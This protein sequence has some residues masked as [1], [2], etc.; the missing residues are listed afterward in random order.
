VPWTIIG[1]ILTAI[2]IVIAIASALT[3]QIDKKIESQINDPAF[4]QKV[5]ERLHLPFYC[6]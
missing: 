5:V 4:I 3:S 6:F 1:V 2:G